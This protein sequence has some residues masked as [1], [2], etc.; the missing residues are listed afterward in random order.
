MI[1]LRDDRLVIRFPEVHADASL[2][3]DFQRTL[4]VPDDDRDHFLPPGLG[5]FP[6]RHVDDF[7]ARV[8]EAW[9]RHGGVMLPMYQSEALW[10][11]FAGSYPFAVK[12][13]TGKIDAVTG[14]AWSDG[15]H[16]DPQ[17]YVVTPDQPWLDG[18]CVER[19]TIRQ[20]VAMPLGAGYTAEEQLTGRAEHG[21]IQVVAYPMKASA[22]EKLR[23][24]VHDELAMMSAAGAADTE[25]LFHMGLAPGGRMKQQIHDDPHPFDVWDTRHRAR[26]FVHIANTLTWRAVTGEAPP[27]MPPTARDYTKA[28]LP[29]FDCYDADRRTLAGANRLAGLKTVAEIGQE[30]GEHPLPENDP[31]ADPSVVDLGPAHRRGRVREWTP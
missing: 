4:R 19:G 16:R 12:I 3:I 2:S 25:V 17:D 29:W 15:L 18:Y 5:S 13:A 27:T 22:W 7:A 11:N 8:P 30:K 6:L 1:E 31:I 24:R 21:G 10:V 9:L 23:H 26:C 14:E 28:G 20:F